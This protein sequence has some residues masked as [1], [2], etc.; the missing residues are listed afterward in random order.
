MTAQVKPSARVDVEL[1]ERSYPILIGN[2]LI[3]GAPQFLAETLPG[4][5]FAIVADEAVRAYAEQLEAGLAGAGLLLGPTVY[6]PSGEASKS[7]ASLERVTAALL[8]LGVERDHAVVALGGGVIGDLAGFAAATL[9]RGV[10]VVQVPTTLLAQVDSSVGGKTG[11][12]TQHGKNLVGAFHQPSLVLID[13][14]TLKT[15]PPREFRAGYAEVAKYGALGDSVF[16]R[17]LEDNAAAIFELD[18]YP[19]TDAVETSV[20]MKAEIV[21]RDEKEAGDRALL[22]LG[23]TFGHAVEAWAGYSG[24]VLHGEAVAL[25]MVLAARF[26]EAEGFCAHTVSRRLEDH[27]AEVGFATTFS[28][29]RQRLGR[30]PTLD[31]LTG[32]MEQDKKV[33]DGKMNLVLLS[34]IGNA[35]V[36][37]DVARDKIRAFL[38]AE[39]E[40]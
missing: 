12:D 35:F 34:G 33:K 38:A 18:T 1:G 32:F 29:L 11:I 15:L 26:S 37:K 22:N 7:F 36:A 4:T 25:G 20:R 23:H 39:L 5:R 9:K 8:D 3:A 16:F 30:A 17:W 28:E 6:V 40:R 21:S 10:R 31:E 2:G 19:L 27:L 14:D 13:L 24:D